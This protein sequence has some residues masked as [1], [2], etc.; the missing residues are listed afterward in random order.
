MALTPHPP[1]H[2]PPADIRDVA[3]LRLPEVPGR[4]QQGETI[5]TLVGR[6]I[7]G[8]DNPGATQRELAN[9]I[10]DTLR[11]HNQLTIPI[12]NRVVRNVEGGMLGDQR[13]KLN[14]EQLFED[15]A[16]RKGG[17]ALQYFAD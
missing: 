14:Y 16:S 1:S 2:P 3:N 8:P 13:K 7:S 11:E 5:S 10:L 6:M 9:T 15:T 12:W 4:Q 17:R